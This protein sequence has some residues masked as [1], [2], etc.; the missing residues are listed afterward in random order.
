MKKLFSYL[1][2]M[3]FGIAG[4]A[5]ATGFCHPKIC[6]PESEFKIW[7]DVNYIYEPLKVGVPVSF[8]FDI[9]SNYN[10]TYDTIHK[11]W[12]AFY[13]K[14]TA[15]NWFLGKYDFGSGI[16]QWEIGHTNFN[17]RTL[18]LERLSWDPL[19]TLRTT[20]MLSGDFTAWWYGDDELRLKKAYLFAKGCETNPVPEPAT[21]LLLGSGLVVVAGFGRK[22]ILKKKRTSQS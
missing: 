9:T 15:N 12:L 5:G 18:E 10:P 17:G 4:V 3:I 6:P 1:I 20:G 13:F 8:K 21:M 7:N 16:Y 14:G 11:A 19:N 22:R 2:L